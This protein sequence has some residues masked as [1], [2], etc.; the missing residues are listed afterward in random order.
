MRVFLIAATVL[1]LSLAAPAAS[2]AAAG[3]VGCDLHFNL[4]GWSV[5]YKSAKGAG[6]IVCDNGAR[7]PV[8]IRV[9]GGGLTVGKSKIVDGH[10]R[11]SGSRGGNDLLGTYAAAGAHAGVVKSSAA[12]VLTKGDISL[13]LAGT[14]AGVDLGVDVSAFT[15]TRR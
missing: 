14:G 15:L 10:G 12:Q 11:F 5:F 7:I 13:A 9:R 1:A 2:A 8:N 3:N 6:T 4:S